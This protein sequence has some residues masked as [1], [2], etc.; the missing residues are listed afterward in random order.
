MSRLSVFR[1][2]GEQIK[3]A[4]EKLDKRF[5]ELE[6]AYKS[7]R[8]ALKTQ[9]D[10]EFERQRSYDEVDYVCKYCGKHE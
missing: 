10:H 3:H 9:C 5:A 4:L 7:Q 8:D 2:S 1:M 6:R